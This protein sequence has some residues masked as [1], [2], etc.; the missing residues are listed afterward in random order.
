MLSIVSWVHLPIGQRQFAQDQSSLRRKCNTLGMPWSYVNTH[1]GPPIG[2]KVNVLTTNG[3]I[4]IT[5]T[6][7][8]T[9]LPPNISRDQANSSMDSKNTLQDTHN[10]NASSEEYPHNA[11]PNIGFVVIPYTQGIA[12]SF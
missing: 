4:T 1:T 7:Y 3:R 8:S 11:K 9:I 6:S 12:A 2:Y 10:P 5:P